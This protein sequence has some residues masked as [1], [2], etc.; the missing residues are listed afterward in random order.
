MGTKISEGRPW[1]SSSEKHF[2]ISSTFRS[3]SSKRTWTNSLIIITGKGH[4]EASKYG[5][6]SNLD[7]RVMYIN[8]GSPILQI[9][10][11]LP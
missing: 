11:Y 7:D 8:L 5:Q 1:T 6:A 9:Q 4:T 3:R 2:G 10:E